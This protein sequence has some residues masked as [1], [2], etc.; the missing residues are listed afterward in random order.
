MAESI[1]GWLTVLEDDFRAGRGCAG[2]DGLALIAEVRRLRKYL[3]EKNGIIAAFAGPSGMTPEDVAHAMERRALLLEVAVAQYVLLLAV[4]NP[5]LD[6]ATAL[7]AVNKH[8]AA[9]GWEVLG[10]VVPHE[11]GRL[12]TVLRDLRDAHAAHEEAE[13]DVLRTL[14]DAEQSDEDDTAVYDAAVAVRDAAAERL[15]TAWAAAQRELDGEAGE[16]ASR[17]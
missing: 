1:E 6:G 15:G 5:G 11:A 16:A 2:A 3:G 17:A 13:A 14:F 10:P 9:L 8:R 7:T 4:S 12:R